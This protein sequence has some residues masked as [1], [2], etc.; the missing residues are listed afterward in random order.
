VATLQSIITRAR[1]EIGDPVAPFTSQVLGDGTTGTLELSRNTID[2][3]T[4]VV[5]ING[6]PKTQNV[7]YTVDSAN[8]ILYF[9]TPPPVDALVLA[10]GNSYTYFTDADMTTFVSTAVAQHLYGRR[11]QMGYQLTLATLPP[12]EEYLI[13]ILVIIEA[14]WVLATSAAFDIDI[15]TPEGVHIP[16]SER[17]QQ[18]NSIIQARRAQYDQMAE[19]LN[20]GLNRI[21]MFDLRRVSRTTNKL[22]PIYVDQEVED[23]RPPQ[24]VFL[25]IDTKGGQI[26]QAVVEPARLDIAGM[27][28]QALVVSINNLGNLTG[29][30][31][32]AHVRPY[33]G[34]LSSLANF[35]VT[36]T[37]VTTGNV[38]IS[39]TGQQTWYIPSNC[40][41]DIETV[42]ASSNVSTLMFGTVYID[43]QGQP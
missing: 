11:D 6:V 17:F 4:L 40:F 30:T 12:I 34:N 18:L 13:A 41:W 21:E 27:A 42:D 9:S 8:A 16:R 20:V 3:S 1:L 10:T 14:L 7:D 22:V 32:K 5:S 28:N 38:T 2:P 24:R 37:N 19:Q 36:V 31:I 26:N 35:T 29:L 15:S 39:L 25:P 23:N 33:P 43:R